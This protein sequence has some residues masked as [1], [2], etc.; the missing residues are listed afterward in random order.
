MKATSRQISISI[1]NQVFLSLSFFWCI[2]YVFLFHS[3]SRGPSK[4]EPCYSISIICSQRATALVQCVVFSEGRRRGK[5][6]G[7]GG[8]GYRPGQ[9]GGGSSR[10]VVFFYTTVWTLQGKKKKNAIHWRMAHLCLPNV[11]PLSG[12]Q[13][14]TQLQNAY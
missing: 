5:R 10:C 4:A 14:I 2:A 13:H 7:G 1:R 3:T 8:G 9:G 12:N 11:M 6:N